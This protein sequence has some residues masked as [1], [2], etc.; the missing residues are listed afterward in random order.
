MCQFLSAIV[1][2]HGDVKCNPLVDSHTDLLELF[3]IHENN[4]GTIETQNFARVEFVP[5]AK[6]GKPNYFDFPNYVLRLDE[7][8]RP[9]WYDAD[10]EEKARKELTKVLERM[11]IT[12]ERKIIAGGAHI[13]GEGAKIGKLISGR[14]LAVHEKAN[15]SGAYLGGADLSG[16]YLGGADLSGAIRPVDPPDGWETNSDGIVVR[17]TK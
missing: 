9:A 1:T 4:A 2:R 17:K 14:I 11:L 8:A 3:S 6:D 5:P 10:I 7:M 15:L 12:S 13:I 16:A